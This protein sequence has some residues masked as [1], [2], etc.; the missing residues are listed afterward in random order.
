MTLENRN[1]ERKY[2]CGN[3]LLGTT[4]P[5]LLVFLLITIDGFTNLLYYPDLYAL[6]FPVILGLVILTAYRN[7]TTILYIPRLEMI[8]G[9]CFMTLCIPIVVFEMNRFSSFM[10]ISYCMVKYFFPAFTFMF[11]SGM[12]YIIES[13]KMTYYKLLYTS[14]DY[15]PPVLPMKT[16]V[17]NNLEELSKVVDENGEEKKGDVI[18]LFGNLTKKMSDKLEDNIK[19]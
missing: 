6:W 11:I 7:M 16:S 1:K 19:K 10:Y 5:L 12:F 2:K 17:Q 9:I 14:K 8:I 3:F 15:V 4:A 13:I 18:D